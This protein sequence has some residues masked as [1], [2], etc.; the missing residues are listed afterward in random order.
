MPSAP[1]LEINYAKD[2]SVLSNKSK[3]ILE[4]SPET[5]E[6]EP[7]RVTERDCVLSKTSQNHKEPNAEEAATHVS[8]LSFPPSL[9][10]PSSYHYIKEGRHTQRITDLLASVPAQ[11]N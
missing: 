8:A 4:G 5:A 9:P 10:I 1:S 2:M 11:S 6:T 7:Q 3:E